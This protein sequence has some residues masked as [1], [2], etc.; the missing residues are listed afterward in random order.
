MKIEIGSCEAKTKLPDLLR[1]VK[2]DKSF[3][4]TNCGEAVADLAPSLGAKAKD[5]C[6]GGK[7]DYCISVNP[8]WITY[9]ISSAL[10]F[11][12]IFSR[13]CVR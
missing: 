3:T 1:Q 6:G 9:K 12:F 2:S 4:I 13:I 11:N 8:F 10:F 5:K 7:H